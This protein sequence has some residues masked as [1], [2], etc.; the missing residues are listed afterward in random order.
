MGQEDKFKREIDKIGLLL[1][2]LLS[3]LLLIKDNKEE[4][5]N[6]VVAQINEG[7]LHQAG[8]LAAMTPEQLIVYLR[9]DQHMQVDNLKKMADV[10]FELS[11][12][13]DAAQY[14]LQSLALYEYVHANG[15]GTV[16][17][18]VMHRLNKTS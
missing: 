9:D 4:A 3:K 12:Q 1:A 10:L 11:E 16:Y 15:A 6:D 14:R 18:D 7:V 2:K 13:A 17:F 8:S 5:V